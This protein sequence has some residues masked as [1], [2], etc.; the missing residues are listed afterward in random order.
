MKIL[1]TRFPLEST[2]GG[3]E[4]QT[5]SLMK[6]LLAKG[7]AAAFLG[8][9][10]TLLKLCKEEGIP[11]AELHI[12]PPPV[13]KWGAVSFFWRKQR[14]QKKLEAALENFS[15]IDAVF[16]LSLSEKLLL[17]EEATK[18][19]IATFWVEHDRVGN[20]LSKNPWLPQLK[21]LS[22]KVTT[23]AVS[24][25]SRKMYVDL[26]WAEEKT[27]AIP[28]GIDLQRFSKSE[29][30]SLKS[31]VSSLHIGTVARLTEDKGVDIVIEAIRTLPD[32]SLTIVGQ[33][34]EEGYLRNMI[35][36]ITDP[37]GITP[38]RIQLVPTVQDLGSF[39]KSL[40][41]FVLPSREHDPFGLVA[42]EA[43]SLGIP[44]IITDACGIAG[45][46][47]DGKD[48]LVVKAD[49]AQDLQKAIESLKDPTER[50]LL[51]DEGKMTAE[52]KFSVES[53]VQKYEDVLLPKKKN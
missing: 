39:Y 10:P 26:G 12:G 5:M 52:K 27:V 53:M 21:K 22:E 32:I 25:L 23:I 20:W 36:S 7:H 30:S 8:S 29:H 34:K 18:K 38:P 16:M 47:T 51:G 43:M 49:S 13:T 19:N 42:A 11:A 17:T 24:E 35:A 46:V 44:T 14:M 48:A 45:Y 4:V 33:G 37:E 6:G 31:Q 2:L 15:G 1:F 28:N 50:K 3:A 9:C 41:A 40:D